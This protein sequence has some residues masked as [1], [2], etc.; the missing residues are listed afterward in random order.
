MDFNGKDYD[1]RTALHIAAAGGHIDAVK[2]LIEVAKVK[3]TKDR[4]IF[5]NLFSLKSDGSLLN[6]HSFQ[7]GIH[8]M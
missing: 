6:P 5:S 8:S 3:I 1:L 4:Y 7:M 2:F